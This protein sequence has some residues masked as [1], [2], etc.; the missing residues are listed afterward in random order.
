MPNNE[1]IPTIS[2]P[3]CTCNRCG[4]TWYPRS[5]VTPHWCPHCNSP[6]WNRP[7]KRPMKELA[8]PKEGQ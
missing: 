7:R 2:I 4:W 1:T 3:V 8:K 5:P 6:Y